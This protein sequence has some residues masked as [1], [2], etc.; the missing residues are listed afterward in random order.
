[1]DTVGRKPSKIFRHW[2][3][4]S[5]SKLIHAWSTPPPL[6]SAV[7]GGGPGREAGWNRFHHRFHRVITQR[8]ESGC[9]SGQAHQP[10]AATGLL[11]G[12]PRYGAVSDGRAKAIRASPSHPVGVGSSV[13]CSSL[14]LTIPVAAGGLR[15]HSRSLSRL[16]GCSAIVMRFR[17]IGW[18]VVGCQERNGRDVKGMCPGPGK[19][20]IVLD[21]PLRH[22]THRGIAAIINRNRGSVTRPFVRRHRSALRGD[23]GWSWLAGRRNRQFRPS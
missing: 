3:T 11:E 21:D 7:A 8:V 15:L 2:P 5:A 16:P 10:V 1:M 9:P 6:T 22:H 19:G 4:W 17:R 12:V 18:P 20:R 13:R 23:S 14:R